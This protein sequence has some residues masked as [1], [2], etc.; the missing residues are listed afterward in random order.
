MLIATIYV[1]RFFSCLYLIKTQKKIFFRMR[2]SY[3]SAQPFHERMNP[4]PRNLI[5]V[6]CTMVWPS[7]VCILCEVGLSRLVNM[8]C[9]SVFIVTMLEPYKIRIYQSCMKYT[10][11]YT[12]DEDPSNQDLFVVKQNAFKRLCSGLVQHWGCLLSHLS[13]LFTNLFLS[14]E[15]SSAQ[16]TL[17]V[18]ATSSVF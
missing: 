5:L 18:S 3:L 8:Y 10:G 12:G 17:S 7:A 9:W 14:P 2:Q 4:L 11:I 13:L 16:S 15:D 6:S 1:C